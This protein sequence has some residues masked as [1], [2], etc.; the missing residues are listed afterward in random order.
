MSNKPFY[1]ERNCF[2]PDED[3]VNVNEKFQ[4][5]QDHYKIKYDIC[6]AQ[7]PKTIVEIGVRAGYSA[8][9]FMQACP[10][11]KYIGIDCQ[12]PPFGKEYT[13]WA[14]KLLRPYDA[15]ILVLDTQQLKTLPFW[16]R[17]ID[18]IHIDGLHTTKAVIHDLDL[19]FP[20]LSDNGMILCDDFLTQEVHL[21]ISKWIQL[22]EQ[23]VNY[24]Y[25]RSRNGELL[26][27][28]AGN[29]TR[30]YKTK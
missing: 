2:S 22:R 20:C 9:V 4:L 26:I 1:F 24:E 14:M 8:L 10:D 29:H 18:F 15:K 27:R 25:I 6:K 17:T 5:F 19:S 7:N 13:Q 23:K 21:G 28:K 3:S 16:K 12:V 30:S 11:A